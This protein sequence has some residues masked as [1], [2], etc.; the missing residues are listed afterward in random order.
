MCRN[1]ADITNCYYTETL[2]ELQGKQARSITGQGVTV[3][4]VGDDIAEYGTSGITAY[5]TGIMYDGV[6]YAGNEDQVSLNLDGSTTGYI[7]SAGTLTGEENPYTLT[8]PDED[9]I[10]TANAAQFQRG[11]V[12]HDGTVNVADATAL[13]DLLLSG[14]EAPAEADVNQDSNINV[15]DVTA[16]IDYLL[17][18]N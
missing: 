11:D 15:S 2:G 7:A 12:N 9:V 17:G 8:M 1:G 5:G 16:L 6:L 18:G 3:E 14:A 13:I 10:I 4:M